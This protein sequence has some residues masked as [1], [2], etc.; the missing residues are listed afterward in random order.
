MNKFSERLRQVL[1]DNGMSQEKKKKKIGMSQ[2]VVTTIA[3]ERENQL[4][5]FLLPFVRCL[6]KVLII[7]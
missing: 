1:K 6:M 4:W 3:L 5:M 2:G 7:C